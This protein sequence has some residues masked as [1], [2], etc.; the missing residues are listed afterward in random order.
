L[1]FSL[2][3]SLSEPASADSLTGSLRF[4]LVT[5]IRADDSIDLAGFLSVV[6]RLDHLE[7]RAKLA[8]IKVSLL[9]QTDSLV[10][11]ETRFETLDH[12]IELSVISML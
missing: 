8:R 7:V 12:A 2:S 11:R 5:A 10:L 4:A 1:L 6:L 3:S 9:L